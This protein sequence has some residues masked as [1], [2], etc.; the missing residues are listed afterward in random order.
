MLSS[1][2]TWLKSSGHLLFTAWYMC[3]SNI[4]TVCDHTMS[5]RIPR[6]FSIARPSC[7][8][9]ESTGITRRNMRYPG[10]AN[11]TLRMISC[12]T[13]LASAKRKRLH[14]GVST[15]AS[16]TPSTQANLLTHRVV[17]FPG[18]NSL[19]SLDEVSQW[20][21]TSM[22]STQQHES[23]QRSTLWIS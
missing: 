9:K 21:L 22:S 23:H 15:T 17:F 18:S 8:L 13:S 12:F 11:I 20:T 16:L 5:P 2:V 4:L 14:P 6:Y 1:S 10:G 3:T 7:L 19:R